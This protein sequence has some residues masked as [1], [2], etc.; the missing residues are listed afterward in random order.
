MALFRRNPPAIQDSVLNPVGP[1][2]PNTIGQDHQV[3]DQFVSQAA[4]IEITPV[5][6]T[7]KLSRAAHTYA[8]SWKGIDTII[9]Y[10]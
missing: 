6:E 2:Q 3:T 1:S 10:V 8:D 9:E 5:L 4:G 7:E